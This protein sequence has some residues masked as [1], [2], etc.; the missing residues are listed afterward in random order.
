MLAEVELK[1]AMGPRDYLLLV[2]A[3]NTGLRVGELS[4]LDVANVAIN[5]VP[6]QTL[7][8]RAAVAKGGQGRL[9]P[10]N[11]L[12]QK[13]VSKL[14]S[15]NRARGFSV[16]DEAPL[17]VTKKHQRLSVRT[18]QWMVEQLRNKA[19]IDF[20]ASPHSIRHAFATNVLNTTGNLRA[21]QVLLGQKRLTSTEVYLHS[22][23]DD[24]AAAVES[25]A[26]RG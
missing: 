19:G 17:F 2:F 23:R 22:R 26:L 15:F 6:R 20:Q 9:V 3:Y 18:I 1:L 4:S 16:S 25:L 8:I 11:S 14:L 12:A 21:V 13:A 10:L 5:G 7:H 24:L